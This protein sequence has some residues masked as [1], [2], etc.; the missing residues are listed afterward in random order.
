MQESSCESSRSLA[1]GSTDPV[2]RDS[3]GSRGADGERRKGVGMRPLE[4]LRQVKLAAKMSTRA[5]RAGSQRAP[6]RRAASNVIESLNYDDAENRL[7]GAMSGVPPSERRRLENWAKKASMAAVLSI[8]VITGSIAQ[9]ITRVVNQID[10]AKFSAVLA[11]VTRGEVFDA[12]ITLSG[13]VWALTL[14]AA[15]LTLWAPEAAGSGIPHVKAYLN[16]CRTP[17]ILRLRTLVAKTVG[18]TFCVSIGM[19]AGREGPMVHAGAIVGAFV[20]RGSQLLARCS[21]KRFARL[22]FS[23]D[24]DT[25]NFVS[26]GAAAGVSAAFNAPIGGILFSLEEVSSYWNPRLTILTFL[27]AAIAA[28]TSAF[29]TS[30]IQGTFESHGLVIYPDD[31]CLS[32][33]AYETWELLVFVALGCCGG[34]VGSAFCLLNK[35]VTLLRKRVFRRLHRAWRVIEALLSVWLVLSVFFALPYATQCETVGSLASSGHHI[36]PHGL[37]YVLFASRLSVIARPRSVR[38]GLSTPFP[39][40]P[41]RA[42]AAQPKSLVSALPWHQLF[43]GISSSASLS[44]EALPAF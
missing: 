25:R 27:V 15:L 19:P 44:T 3:Q 37:W 38:R 33:T 7:L 43:P 41:V 32:S 18:I 2:S 1:E 30:G 17:G 39:P 42:C 29:W 28:L 10:T 31:S 13:I 40:V 12:Y 23:N 36:D 16:G 26:M 24:Y 6:A 14:G 20:A 9:A 8:G 35:R 4:K 34:L 5:R 22:D 21:P 11:A